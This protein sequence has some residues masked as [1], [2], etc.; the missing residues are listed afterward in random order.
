MGQLRMVCKEMDPELEEYV[1]QAASQ[2]NALCA[3][4]PPARRERCDAWRRYP[5]SNGAVSGNVE[6]AVGGQQTGMAGVQRLG[7]QNGREG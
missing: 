7:E 5:P 1:V 6:S 2:V 4:A 3:R